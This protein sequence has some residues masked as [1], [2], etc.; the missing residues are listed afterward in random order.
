MHAS[1]LS[2]S[3]GAARRGNAIARVA[4]PG[5]RYTH[6]AAAANFTMFGVSA[7]SWFFAIAMVLSRNLEFPKPTVEIAVAALL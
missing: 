1:R 4:R 6:L 2:S 7:A 5:N 3:H